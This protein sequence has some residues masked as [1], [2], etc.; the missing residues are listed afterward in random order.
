METPCRRLSPRV[1]PDGSRLTVIL[2]NLAKSVAE[3]RGKAQADSLRKT[4]TS[5]L[6]TRLVGYDVDTDA[7]GERTAN[8]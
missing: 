7:A 8:D 3:G 6:T 2:A 4:R 5:T 1:S